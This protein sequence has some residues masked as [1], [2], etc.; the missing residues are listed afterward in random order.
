MKEPWHGKHMWIWMLNQTGPLE[1]ILRRSKDMGLSGLLVKAWDGGTSGLFLEQFKQMA[2]PAKDMGLT[3]GAWGYSYGTNVTGE[4]KA[5][6]KALEE[7]A[8]WLVIDAEDEYETREGKNKALRLG[9]E[10]TRDLQQKTVIGYTSFALPKYHETF[11]YQEF[12]SFCSVCLPQVYWSLM[13]FSPEEAIS[14]SLRGL[15]RYGLPVAP[16]GQSY[17]NASVD[18]ITRFSNLSYAHGLDGI[19]FYNWQHA[20][21]A[22]L[23]AVGRAGYRKNGPWYGAGVRGQKDVIGKE[24]QEASSTKKTFGPWRR[25]K[26]LFGRKPNCPLD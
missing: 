6:E 15:E 11:P 3:V 12:S 9:L 17:G 4:V 16:V 21:E 2:G 24:G 8:D 5:M 23:E 25:L 26:D 20:S 18:E 22:Q 13:G 7:G 14:M 1:Q 10:I 19:S